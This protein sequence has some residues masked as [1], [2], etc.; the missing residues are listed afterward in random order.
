MTLFNFVLKRGEPLVD[1]VVD[2]ALRALLRGEYRAGDAFPSVRAIAANLK[3]HP[4]TA[5]KAVQHLIDAK[6]LETRPGIGTVVS[7]SP[8]SLDRPAREAVLDE[9]DQ[10]VLHARSQGMSLETMIKR[11]KRRWVD[12]DLVLTE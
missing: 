8:R 3:I 6:W 9:L 4:N 1:Q 12:D 7:N 5:H 10:V 2:A 11:I